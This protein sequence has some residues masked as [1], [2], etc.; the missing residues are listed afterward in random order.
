MNAIT[1]SKE[2]LRKELTENFSARM[3]KMQNEVEASQAPSSQEVMA[4]ISKKVSH[5]KH[6]GNED[7]FNFN[8]TVEDHLDAAKKNMEKV[9]PKDAEREF[10]HK[11]AEEL[12]KSKDA[13]RLRSKVMMTSK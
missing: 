1:S 6:T 7:Q 5:F 10:V 11:A 2:D 4:K 3:D 13:G 8:S 12:D 9:T